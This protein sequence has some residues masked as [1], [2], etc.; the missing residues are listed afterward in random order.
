ML[1]DLVDG[2]GVAPIGGAEL[3]EST[4]GVV[5]TPN[6]HKYWKMYKVVFSAKKHIHKNGEGRDYARLQSIILMLI[7]IRTSSNVG[8]IQRTVLAKKYHKIVDSHTCTSHTITSLL[9]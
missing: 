7:P 2:P 3:D 4:A 1:D 9:S 8:E 5:V 6:T